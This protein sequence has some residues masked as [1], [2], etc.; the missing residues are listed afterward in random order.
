MNPIVVRNIAIGEG[1]PKIC[2]PIVEQTK[3]EILR[4]AE[5]IR[6][7]P[8]DLVEWRADWFVD[9]HQG[10]AVKELLKELRDHI[11]NMPILFTFRTEAEGGEQSITEEEYVNLHKLAVDSGYVDL[12]DVEIF[13]MCKVADDIITYA[14]QAGVRVIGSNHD[15]LKTPKKEE[16][17]ERLRKMQERG[18]DIPKIAVMPQSKEDVL[19]LL[20]ATEE[21]ASNYADRPIITMSMGEK[22][23]IS[24]VS[25]ELTGSAVTFGTAGKASAPGQI[26]T[27]ELK[28]MLELLHEQS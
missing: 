27:N 3:A 4:L 18:V 8:A 13:S 26:P 20:S 16:L 19:T 28:V 5:D 21:M 7:M 25:G 2:V 1:L 11:G 14:K 24:R 6:E 23:V 10:E 9:V 22:G 17:I 12:I 15:F